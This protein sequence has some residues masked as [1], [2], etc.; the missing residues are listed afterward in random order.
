MRAV[1]VSY[2]TLGFFLARGFYNFSL[3]PAH[4][5]I[6]VGSLSGYDTCIMHQTNW[7]HRHLQACNF[8]FDP[9]WR[10]LHRQWCIHQLFAGRFQDDG[11]YRKWR[12]TLHRRGTRGEAKRSAIKRFLLEECDRLAA[13]GLLVGGGGDLRWICV[14]I[15]PA[16]AV[17]TPCPFT[18][19]ERLTKL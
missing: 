5:P 2:T 3:A 14:S 15:Q 12:V 4:R 8:V 19:L 13:R 10:R 7:V 9:G 1:L 16:V 17:S 18:T 6:V 11:A